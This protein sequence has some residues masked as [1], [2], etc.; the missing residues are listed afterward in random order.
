MARRLAKDAPIEWVESDVLD[1]PF[2]NG[3]FDI[4]I[5]QHGYHYFPDKP[6]ALEEFRRILKPRGRIALSIWTGHSPYT[7][8]LC[9][10]VQRHI[11]PEVAAKQSAQRECPTAKDLANELTAAGFTD[12]K[13]V[14]QELDISV[15]LAE[16]FVPLHLASMPI[17]AEF[18]S[19]PERSRAAL[20]TEVSEVM[21]PYA[22]GDRLI[23]PDSVHVMTGRA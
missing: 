5:A 17:A 7:S 21:K 16:E 18:A 1:L 23:Y 22:S 11:S 14:K 15:P 19:L 20:I 12:V 3:T 13:V 4:V 2:Y 10:A 8:A 6:A 9:N